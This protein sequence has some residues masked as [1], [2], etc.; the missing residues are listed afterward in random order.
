MNME[1]NDRVT[2]ELRDELELFKRTVVTR[3]SVDGWSNSE[4]FGYISDWFDREAERVDEDEA[5][6]S[7]FPHTKV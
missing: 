3:F 6:D 4:M 5:E 2:D 7:G 1:N